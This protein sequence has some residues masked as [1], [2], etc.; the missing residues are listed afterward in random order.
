VGTWSGAPRHGLHE[1][2]G[3]LHNCSVPKVKKAGA[4]DAVLPR[5]IVD[6]PRRFLAF[7]PKIKR[8][9]RTA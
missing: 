4:S 6:N 9:N 1:G 2:F 8:S 3:K 5:I 7:V